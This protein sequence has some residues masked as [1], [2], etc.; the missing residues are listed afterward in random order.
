MKII[1]RIRF[2]KSNFSLIFFIR[3]G[4]E[5]GIISD[6]LGVKEE[7]GKGLEEELSKEIIVSE[8]EIILRFKIG[9]TN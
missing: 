9:K 5:I 2:K 3:E 4:I 7:G 8:A 6:K 1:L